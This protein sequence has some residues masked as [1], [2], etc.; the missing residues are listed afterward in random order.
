MHCLHS[1]LG[2]GC[3][4]S[5]RVRCWT[6]LPLR[7]AVSRRRD[8]AM[9]CAR[10]AAEPATF[11]IAEMNSNRR[12]L[13]QQLEQAVKKEDYAAAARLKTELDLLE[14]EHPQLRLQKA[15]KAA[16]AK[17]KYQVRVPGLRGFMATQSPCPAEGSSASFPTR[18]GLSRPGGGDSEATSSGPSAHCSLCPSPFSTDRLPFL[19]TPLLAHLLQEAAQIQ[20]QLRQLEAELAAQQAAAAAGGGGGG[21]PG[22]ASELD[23]LSTSS[24]TVTKNIRIRVKR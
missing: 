14:T 20:L 8:S 9:G 22:S 21:L 7:S 18:K 1:T 4:G 10:P 5:G 2:V 16:I 11:N 6:G 23:E 19:P 17:E 12:S 24:D 3:S 15:L 13:Q